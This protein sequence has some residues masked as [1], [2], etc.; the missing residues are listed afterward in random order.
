MFW[1][2]PSLTMGKTPQIYAWSIKFS[3]ITHY[4]LVAMYN[5][6][7][8]RV[9]N[10]GSLIFWTYPPLI[11]S[12]WWLGATYDRL[13]MFCS[14]LPSTV[15]KT[16]QNISDTSNFLLP[17]INWLVARGN[18]WYQRVT[19]DRSSMFWTY[20]LPTRSKIPQNMIKFPIMIH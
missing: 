5:N 13:S 3:I 19:N 10:N 15:S 14:Y 17:L 20:P 7:Q 16:P 4:W 18:N 9:T 12:N 1:S 6:L 2:Y 11:M 8:P